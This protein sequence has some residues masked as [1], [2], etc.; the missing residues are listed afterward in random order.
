MIQLKIVS[1]VR[2]GLHGPRSQTHSVIKMLFVFGISVAF[3]AK[4]QA[5]MDKSILKA[6]KRVHH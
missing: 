5:V 6:A 2:V 4:G 1:S 3:M